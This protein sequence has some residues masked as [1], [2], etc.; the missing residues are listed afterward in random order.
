MVTI[1]IATLADAPVLAALY[2]PYVET[3]DITF[4]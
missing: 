2:R 3:T 4:E 1:R